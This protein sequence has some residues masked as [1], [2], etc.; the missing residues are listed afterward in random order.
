MPIPGHAACTGA[1]EKG[2]EWRQLRDRAGLSRDELARLAGVDSSTIY[3]LEHG[4]PSVSDRV[5]RLVELTVALALRGGREDVCVLPRQHRVE[6]RVLGLL[7]CGRREVDCVD[8]VG[9]GRF[10]VAFGDLRVVRGLLLVDVLPMR[11]MC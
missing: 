3:R 7:D 10:G 6:N 1:P 2:N 11:W 4:H 9:L 8:R 5:R